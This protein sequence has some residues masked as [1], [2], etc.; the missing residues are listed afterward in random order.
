MRDTDAEHS[1]P[2]AWQPETNSIWNS[3]NIYNLPIDRLPY[4][5]I[6]VKTVAKY[7]DRD[8]VGNSQSS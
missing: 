4:V 6:I 3:C 7:F 2:Y 5:C 1:Y 8:L